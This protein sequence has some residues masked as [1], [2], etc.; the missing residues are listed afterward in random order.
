MPAKEVGKGRA[1]KEGSIRILTGGDGKKGFERGNNNSDSTGDVGRSREVEGKERN[2]VK[3]TQQGKD[4]G[5]VT[6]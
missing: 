3:A 4:E 1:K 2:E 5:H 6:L